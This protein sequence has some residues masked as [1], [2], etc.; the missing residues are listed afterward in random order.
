MPGRVEDEGDYEGE[1]LD[2][3]H[4][5]A[6]GAAKGSNSAAKPKPK[7]YQQVKK[8]SNSETRR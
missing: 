3:N 4:V 8:M 5:P 1:G 7:Q 6:A 2:N